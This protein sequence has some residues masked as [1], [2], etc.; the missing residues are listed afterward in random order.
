[1]DLK[2]LKRPLISGPPAITLVVV[3]L[4]YALTQ[5]VNIPTAAFASAGKHRTYTTNFPLAEDPISERGI[6]INGQTAGLDWASVRTTPGL[7]LGT[8]SGEVTTAPGKYD[9]STALL[10]GAWG[11]NQTAQ[12]T[13]HTVNR[14]DKIYEEVELRLRSTLT[15]H[16]ATGYEINFRCSKTAKAY[17]QIVRWNGPLGGF[18]YV[19]TGD[20]SQYGVANGDA[21]KATIVGNVITA[22]INGVRV[23]H[24]TDSTYSSGSPGIGFYIEG[25][26]GVNGNYGFTSFAATDE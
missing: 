19:K 25:T 20:G 2:Y 11:P 26:T 13:V 24:G 4:G 21:I 23:L 1:M 10:T 8:E 7:A 12:A 3:L 6:R 18:T 15:P 5:T 17:T 22:Y 14:N 9:D 16:R